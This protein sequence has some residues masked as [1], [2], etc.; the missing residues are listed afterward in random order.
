M[1]VG[2]KLT[3]ALE[4]FERAVTKE[5][6]GNKTMMDKCLEKA[7]QLEREGIAAGESWDKS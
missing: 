3:K 5:A 1:P 4:W 7:I 2:E 6:E